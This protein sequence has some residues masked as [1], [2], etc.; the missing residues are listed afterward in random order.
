[1]IR[2]L[3]HPGIIKIYEFYQDQKYF[4]IVSDLCTGGELFDRIV[5]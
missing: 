3:D 1:M 4:Y 2:Q 5:S